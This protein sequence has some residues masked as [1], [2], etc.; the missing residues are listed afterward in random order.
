MADKIYCRELEDHSGFV[1]CFGGFLPPEPASVAGRDRG[2][3]F[4]VS[5]ARGKQPG[6]ITG[7]DILES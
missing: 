7:K 6:K 3:R 2:K 1:V 5:G 4:L